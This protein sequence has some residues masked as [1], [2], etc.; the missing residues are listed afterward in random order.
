MDSERNKKERKAEEEM[1]GTVKGI[2]RRG[3]QKKR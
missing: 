1:T 2:R 3:R